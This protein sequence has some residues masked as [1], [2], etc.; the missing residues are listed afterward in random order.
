VHIAE[1]KREIDGGFD[2][3]LDCGLRH[4]KR[5]PPRLVATIERTRG[6]EQMRAAHGSEIEERDSLFGH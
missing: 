5:W 4:N 3:D 6:L 1:L 2:T